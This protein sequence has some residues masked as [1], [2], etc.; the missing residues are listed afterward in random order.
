MNR[1]TGSKFTTFAIILALGIASSGCVKTE[2]DRGYVTEQAKFDEIKE[3]VS[4]KGDVLQKLGSPSTTSSFSEEIGD[5]KW[6]Y[7]S[8]KLEK[9]AFFTPDVVEREIYV[10]SFDDSG[11][12]RDVSRYDNSSARNIKIADDT[13]PTEGNEVTIMQQLL[14]NLGKFNPDQAP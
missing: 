10:V 6:Y 11:I 3:G 13:T 1:A 7:V 12:V 8:M 5:E 9:K 4:S 2:E 14:G